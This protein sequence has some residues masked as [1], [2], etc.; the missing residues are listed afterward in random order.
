MRTVLILAVAAIQGILAQSSAPYYPLTVGNRW[1]YDSSSVPVRVVNDT[2]MP[3]GRIY[4][5]LDRSD[6]AGG[7]YVRTDSAYVYYYGYRQDIETRFFSLK[8]AV[9]DTVRIFMQERTTIT[10]IDSISVFGKKARRIRYRYDALVT[11]EFELTEGFGL[12][13]KHF[14]GDPPPPWPNY[15]NILTGCVVNGV[16]FGNVV[17]VIVCGPDVPDQFTLGQNFPN[18]FNPST[19]IPFT[20]SED[21]STR[22]SVFDMLGREVAVVAS[23]FRRAGSYAEQWTAQGLASGIY[24]YQLISGGRR[25]VRTFHLLR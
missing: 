17:K 12:T 24:F 18:P 11:N 15:S 1:Y 4:T 9:G 20:L 14:Y 16:Q 23:G 22:L 25:T 19:T 21:G 2:L 6:R 3:N 7:I 8:G 13:A 5:V 10:A